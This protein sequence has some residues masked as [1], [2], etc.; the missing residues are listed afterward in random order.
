MNPLLAAE[1]GYQHFAL[2]GGE[3]FI[4]VGLCVT[5]LLAIFVGFLLIRGVLAAD[6]GT[7]TMQEIAK[8]IQ[9][10]AI[11]YLKRQFRTIVSSSIPLAVIVFVTSVAVKKADGTT[12][13]LSFG[14]VRPFSHPGIRSRLRA[15]PA[16][17]AT[18][19]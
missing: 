13:A 18:S 2:H 3:W 5:A 15:C 16:S 6:Q 9:E 12:E 4:L 10:G 19:A 1:G 7:P 11:A 14:A 17:R 8:A